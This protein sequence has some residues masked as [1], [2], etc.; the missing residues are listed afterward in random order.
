MGPVN[1]K[2]INKTILV[3]IS[4]HSVNK[5]GPTGGVTCPPQGSGIRLVSTLNPLASAGPLIWIPF[6]WAPIT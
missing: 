2:I 3:S 1:Q 5:P 4:S 6:K